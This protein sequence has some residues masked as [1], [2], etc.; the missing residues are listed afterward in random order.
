[1]KQLL[2]TLLT[3]ILII[4]AGVGLSAITYANYVNG[5]ASAGTDGFKDGDAQGYK[6]GLREGGEA[7]YQEGSRVYYSGVE[8]ADTDNISLSDSYYLYNPS[9]SEVMDFLDKEELYSFPDIHEYTVTH[10]IRS[11]YVRCYVTLNYSSQSEVACDLVAFDT[12]DKGI[13]IIEPWSHREVIVKTGERYRA[14]LDTSELEIN[15][16]VN[17]VTVL[18]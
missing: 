15:G 3:I 14:A 2:L 10:S 16:M 13:V 5:V 1:M 12:V 11:G 9:F 7:G 18:W 6:D 4:G 8:G 17:K